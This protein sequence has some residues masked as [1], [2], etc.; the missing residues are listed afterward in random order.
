MKDERT[1]K[2]QGAIV[3]SVTPATSN[4][5]VDY[6]RLRE[7][8]QFIVNGG[9]QKGKGVLM[10]A[11]GGGEGYFLNDEQWK[12][13]IEILVDVARGEVP[14]M[15]GVF[16]LNANFA[17]EK[18]KFAEKLGIDF[19]Q[20]APP[21]YEKPTDPEVYTHYKIA[22]DAASKIGIIV[23]HTYWAVP[24][25]YEITLPLMKKLAKLEN[26]VGTKWASAHTQN[27]L[28]VLFE[29]GDEFA[30][31]DNQGWV[32]KVK[33]K[34]GMDA[35][36]YFVGNYDPEA[37]VKVADLFLEDKLDEFAKEKAKSGALR[38]EVMKAILE[39]VHGSGTGEMTSMGEGT[40]GKAT[41]DI[42]GRPMGP[43]FPPQ[44]QLSEEAKNKI[45]AKHEL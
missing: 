9:V 38:E 6:D 34:N 45:K 10:V 19:I 27:F 40:L 25:Y 15:A 17:I 23:Y 32:D 20:L 5:D 37:A 4:Y 2:I 44:H 12:K 1:E 7:Q 3:A 29:L 43:P 14:T 18:I 26:V 31:I 42:V 8:L 33:Q 35:F 30:F 24:E 39:E 41:M 16:E 21:H 22:S 28:D 36:M 11:G 13:T